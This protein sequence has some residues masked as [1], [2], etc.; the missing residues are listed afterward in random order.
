M[1]GESDR[2][3]ALFGSLRF[4]RGLFLAVAAALVAVSGAAARELPD[5]AAELPFRLTSASPMSGAPRFA[6]L[7]DLDGDGLDEC[8]RV[9]RAGDRTYW[10]WSVERL[11][12]RSRFP[13]LSVRAL[14]QLGCAGLCDLD[15]DGVP[16]A[17]LWRQDGDRV[18]LTAV[19][20]HPEREDA[21]LDTVASFEW[22]VGEGVLP[23][24][25]WRGDVELVGAVDRDGDGSDDSVV[26]LLQAGTLGRPREILLCDARSG[27]TVWSVRTGACPVGGSALADLTGDGSPEIVVGL[28]PSGMPT[29]EGEWSDLESRVVALDALGRTLWSRELGGA[30]SGVT[31]RVADLT[32]DG[33]SEIVA[34]V[35]RP[36][37]RGAPGLLVFDRAGELLDGALPDVSV[38][39]IEVVGDAVFLACVDGV[40][41]RAVLRDGSIEVRDELRVDEELRMVR[42][43]SLRPPLSHDGVFFATS[44]GVL[45]VATLRLRPLAILA[46]AEAGPARRDPF[47]LGTFADGDGQ[48][49]G[50][51]AATSDRLRFLA[52]RR[53]DIGAWLIALGAAVVCLSVLGA[54][55]RW[56]RAS[57]GWL[58]ERITPTKERGEVI[59]GTLLELRTG[60][61]GKLSITRPVRYLADNLRM[62]GDQEGGITDSFAARYA[63][64][65][66]TARG[67]GVEALD[68]IRRSAERVGL[69]PEAAAALAESVRRLRRTLSDVR[70]DIPSEAE[71][72]RLANE[73]EEASAP[74]TGALEEIRRQ[75]RRERSASLGA[76]LE[77]ALRP[78]R[79]EADAAG[80]RFETPDLRPLR[81]LR[82]HGTSGELEHAF[83]NLTGNAVRALRDAVDPVLAISCIQDANEV[84]VRFEDNG[85][86]IDESRHE[87]IFFE[88]VSDRE[89]GGAGLPASREAL[90]RRGGD[91]TLVRSAPGRGAVFEVRLLTV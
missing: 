17:A 57:L 44:G 74:V 43:V 91:V 78:W 67:G 81:G 56:R 30:G 65:V 12:E 50:F 47:A 69:A 86:G 24:G 71:S 27:E 18:L 5:T 52:L 90:R 83:D 15:A 35:L 16:E 84:R 4:R 42:L 34:G 48:R 28:E 32:G 76:C 36:D 19:E 45:G 60:G 89:G 64:M 55:P 72:V 2:R 61:H 73:L 9:D 77:S 23:N 8:V 22:F 68:R 88:G 7:V 85:K 41:R 11:I 66:E 10:Q 3:V 58:R 38:A 25:I 46:T 63:E 54:V 6:A 21:R 70:T 37:P 31:V 40:L 1:S 87:A 14:D 59:D 82:V 33:G 49:R 39:D 53:R 26:V 80:V 79:A 62:L 75:A 13:L 20:V 51:A 29:L